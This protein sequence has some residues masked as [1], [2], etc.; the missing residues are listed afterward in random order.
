MKVN[1][2]KYIYSALA[3]ICGLCFTACEDDRD[4]NPTLLQPET[5]VLNTPAYAASVIDLANSETLNFTCS[6]PEFGY[7]AAATY[8]VELSVKNSFTVSFAEAEA[9]EDGS[10]VADYV[11]IDDF[12]STCAISV[13]ASVFAKALQQVAQWD[14]AAVP[15]TQTVNVRLTST[16]AG[17][18]VVSNVVDILVAPYY[19]ELKDAAP[20]MWYLIGSCIGDG[21][22]NNTKG[23]IGTS[24][25]PMSLVK[26]FSYDK[27]TGQGELK[28][29]GYLTPDGFK[30]VKTP[31]SWD[32]Q[33][34]QGAAFG[35]FVK[36]D[37]GSGN[38][39]VPSAGYYTVTLNTATD[40]LKVEAAAITPT[41]YPSISM[42]GINGDW[43]NDLVMN[44]VNTTVANNHVWSLAVNAA[45]N[46]EG[47]FRTTGDWGTNWG[48]DTFPIGFGTGGGPNIAIA[49][50]NYMVIFND[51]DGTYNFIT[52]E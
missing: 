33:W 35:T 32:D 4:S 15:A 47:K 21:A 14:E 16:L 39:T 24:I 43:D 41:V 44:A 40:E 25:Y 23:G 3:L 11:T 1:M 20:E 37:G 2:K 36:N 8:H 26:D 38:I 34:G 9:A 48:A 52:V 17:Q 49:A 6:Q 22:W 19:V 28:F 7:T 30:L 50:G 45:G 10:L 5:F 42:I 18:K 12:Y 31:G 46:T 29:T 51:I 13:D 27:K